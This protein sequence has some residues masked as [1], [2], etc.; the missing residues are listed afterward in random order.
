MSTYQIPTF[1]GYETD[2]ILN[3]LSRIFYSSLGY[4][5]KS[6][7][8]NEWASDWF[9]FKGAN[10]IPRNGK[11]PIIKYKEYRNKR[12]EQ[13]LFNDWIESGKFN[14]L[15]CM[16][17]KLS[18]HTSILNYA[19]K[20]L[21]LNFADF[22][23]ELAIK[24]FCEYKGRQFTLQQ[25]AEVCYIVQ[26]S[27]DPTHCHVYWI[28][29]KPMSKRTLDKDID[30]FRK[31]RNNQ[32]P[33]IEFKGVGDVAF[34]SGGYHENGSQYLPIGTT[35]LCIIEEL[36]EH[37]ES[38]CRKYDLPVSDTERN[39]IRLSSSPASKTKR[40]LRSK[41]KSRLLFTF[42][43]HQ[44]NFDEYEIIEENKEKIESDYDYDDISDIEQWTD[45]CEGSRNNILFDRLR[46]YFNKNKDL[47]TSEVFTRLA[48]SLNERFCKPP[49]SHFEVNAIANS[50][51]GFNNNDN[52]GNQ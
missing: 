20:G 28:S 15:C 41:S 17:G 39:K 25:M 23:N 38:I 13:E 49:L 50:I 33:S 21:Y 19:R 5:V 16:I 37:I 43:K 27:D 22:D 6:L 29:S 10:T 32:L 24:E 12:I 3:R 44:S 36:G 51:L 45:I 9:Y 42:D 30:I 2:D 26:H 48:H 18:G 31:I 7:T 52:G 8:T 35:E 40:G 4:N 1:K 47:L 14:N 34:C 46:K 11:I